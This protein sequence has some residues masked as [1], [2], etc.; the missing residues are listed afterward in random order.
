MEFED[1]SEKV[2]WEARRVAAAFGVGEWKPNEP[3][4]EII[5]YSCFNNG[6]EYYVS[7]DTDGELKTLNIDEV[8]S[9]QY[10]HCELQNLGMGQWSLYNYSQ[11]G[12]E[13]A[14]GLYRL[15]FED[16]GILSQLP[17]ISAHEKLELR[18]SMPREFW[19]QKW[20]DEEA[21]EGNGQSP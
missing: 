20:L 6:T 7:F 19:P 17:P 3:S 1:V 10:T 13:M 4:R 21:R 12:K 8:E 15:G 18:F 5:S 9:R 16:E 2:E 14:Y 11:Y